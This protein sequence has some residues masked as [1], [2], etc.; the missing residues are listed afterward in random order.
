MGGGASFLL[1]AEETQVGARALVQ[2]TGQTRYG[3]HSRQKGWTDP[4]DKEVPSS[5]L[6]WVEDRGERLSSGSTNSL[7]L[8]RLLLF[9]GAGCTAFWEG[10][11]SDVE[12]AQETA[13]LG[14]R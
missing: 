9:P 4:Q 6:F 10:S 3:H 8:R 2:K 12:L 5:P 13:P 11:G 14:G 1:T 7:V